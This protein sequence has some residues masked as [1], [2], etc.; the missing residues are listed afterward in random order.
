MINRASLTRSNHSIRKKVSVAMGHNSLLRRLS[1]LLTSSPKVYDAIQQLAGFQKIVPLLRPHFEAVNGYTLL[2]VGAGTG[3]YLPLLPDGVKYI[4]SDIDSQKL[5]GFKSR[6]FARPAENTFGI[7]SDSLKIALGD[8]SVDFALCAA[9][10]HHIAD[11]DLSRLFAELARVVRKK[12]IFLDAVKSPRLISRIL[13]AVDRGSYPRPE[14]AIC[15]MIE[16]FFD[17]DSKQPYKIYH[18]Y[19]LCSCLPKG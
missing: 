1:D 14:P 16:Q 15:S 12:L 5:D 9:M 11:D 18:Q 8:K 10:S 17:I 2:D 19:I 4:W 6:A 3:L 13:W 7:M